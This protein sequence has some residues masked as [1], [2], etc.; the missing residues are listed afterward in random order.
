[1]RNI[2][3]I[4]SSH[5]RATLHPATT[6]YGCNCRVKDSCPLNGECLTPK[7][8]YRADIKNNSNNK[9]KYYVGLSETTFKQRYRNHKKE[10]NHAKYQ[11]STELSK[12]IW[13]LKCDKIN[14]TIKWSIVERVNGNANSMRCNLCLTEKLWIIN[15]INDENCL[16][17]KS[18]LISKCRHL[19]K[20]LLKSVKKT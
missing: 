8:V 4:I 13:K 10:L 3:S 20:V 16:N 14:F 2:G 18:E 9:K 15:C 6:S 11:N 7:L 5:N 17:K 19:N 12:Y 1:M